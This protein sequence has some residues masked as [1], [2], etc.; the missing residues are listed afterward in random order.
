M[1]QLLSTTTDLKIIAEYWPH[2]FKR[3]GTT[4][5]EFFDFFNELHY[6]FYMIDEIPRKKI[7]RDY[8]VENVDKPFEFSF[9]VLITKE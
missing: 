6:Q 7:S 2:G 8:I 9:N 3:A 4:A 1:K 5:V